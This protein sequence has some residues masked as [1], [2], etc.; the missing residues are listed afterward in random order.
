MEISPQPLH[1]ITSLL[2]ILASLD[3]YTTHPQYDLFT[4]EVDL[5]SIFTCNDGLERLVC[6]LNILIKC[7]REE[8]RIISSYGNV[9]II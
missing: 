6:F 1:I 2:I 3:Q 8:K 5:F 9:M 4:R 7:E